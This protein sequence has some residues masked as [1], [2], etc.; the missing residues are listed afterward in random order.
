[1]STYTDAA[2]LLSKA[3][4]VT[5]FRSDNPEPSGKPVEDNKQPT[6]AKV[7]AVYESLLT[8]EARGVGY[9][10]VRRE[11]RVSLYWVRRIHDEM[12]AAKAALYL[13]VE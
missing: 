5:K 3:V 4:G 13:P 7:K 12:R 2:P 10:G 1:M 8:M 11:T 6:Q 9:A